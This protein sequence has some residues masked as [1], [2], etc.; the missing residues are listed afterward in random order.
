MHTFFCMKFFSL[1]IKGTA[2]LYSAIFR[3]K[4]KN[5]TEARERESAELY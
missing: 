1:Y 4:M 3:I 5:T 2:N